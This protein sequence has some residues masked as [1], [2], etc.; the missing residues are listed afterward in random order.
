MN[1]VAILAN[2]TGERFASNIPKQFHRINGKMVIEYVI[3]SIIESGCADKI[4]ISTD[5]SANSIY[6]ADVCNKYGIDIIDGG[7][8]RNRTLKKVIDYIADTYTCSKLIVCDAVRPMITPGLISLYFD[9]LNDNTAVVTAQ[10]ITD[11][12]GCYSVRQINRED[13]YLMQSPEGFDFGTLAASFDSESKLTEVTQQLPDDS[14]IKLYFGFNNNIKL[15]YPADLKYLEALIKSRENEI[16]L[17]DI[18]NSVTRLKG[19]LDSNYPDMT[20][21]W[22]EA[23][24]S[25]FPSLLEKW[26]IDSYTAL[27]TSHF[28]IVFIAHSIKYGNCVIKLIPPF[29]DRYVSERSCYTGLNSSFMCELYDYDDK[30]SSLLLERCDENEPCF[31]GNEELI[32]SLF[33]RLLSASS[34][35]GGDAFKDYRKILLSKASQKD[36]DYKKELI[37]AYVD[38]AV[39][40]YERVFSDAETRL[41]HGDMHRYNIMSRD[42]QLTAIDPIGYIAPP[43]FDIARYMGTELSDTDGDIYALYQ[44][45]LGSFSK[46]ADREELDSALFIDIVFRLHNSLYENDTYTLTDKWLKVLE[47]VY[48]E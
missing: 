35:A 18:L 48:Y 32:L 47:T 16:D 30:C 39:A 19:Y 43:V 45:M 28:G 40:E 2:G 5:V 41:I 37:S 38:K 27:K 4:I 22:I 17:G 23:I 8:T 15:T 7:D 9:Y 36:Y 33:S 6:I 29:I 14:K 10:K 26:Q 12:L 31:D 34:S 42:S 25:D 11:S 44:R 3:D 20:A 46:L 24:K 1:I 21:A 13:Y